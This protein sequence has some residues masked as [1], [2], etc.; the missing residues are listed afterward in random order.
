[1]ILRARAKINLHLDVGSRRQDGF[2]SLKT[3]FQ[4][5]SLH[6]TLEVSV[7]PQEIL[8]SVEPKGLPTN[9]DNLVV[10]AL[11]ALRKKLG[12]TQGMRVH[13]KKRIPM[14]AGLGGGSSDAAAALWGGWLLWKSKS[15]HKKPKRIPQVLVSLARQLGAD[16]P[17]F[18]KGGTAW[19]GGIGE[20]LKSV[21]TPRRRWLVLVYPKVHV[22]TPEAYRLLDEYRKKKSR[23]KP[24]SAEKYFNSFEP[25]IFEKYPEIARAKDILK[26]LGCTIVMMSGSGST[27]FGFVKTRALGQRVIRKLSRRRW[28]CF[29]CH[30]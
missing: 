26:S 29:L 3:L 25:V 10:R 28:D 15:P 7:M 20:K 4:E 14:G 18:L 24:V 19:A 23:P 11:E 27:V 9:S 5:I 2:H 17:F 16:V 12:T 6:D 13:L 21:K 30:T 22:S 8:L 1:M